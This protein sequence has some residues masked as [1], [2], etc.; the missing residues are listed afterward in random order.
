MVPATSILR[1]PIALDLLK[2]LTA[3]KE[4]ALRIAVDL[5]EKTIF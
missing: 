4:V 1:E 5:P 3:P 2:E